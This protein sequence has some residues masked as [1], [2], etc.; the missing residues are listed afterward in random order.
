MIAEHIV[1]NA[2]D[3]SRCDIIA[4]E[5]A[6]RASLVRSLA[7]GQH[8]KIP[9]ERRFTRCRQ[10]VHGNN[11]IHVKTAYNRN[12]GGHYLLRSMPSFFNSSA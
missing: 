7:P 9:A 2:S 8:L 3:H 5:F 12:D 1:T 6:G 4:A 11:K 10:A